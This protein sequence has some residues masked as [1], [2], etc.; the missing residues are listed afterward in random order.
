MPRFARR[1][2]WVP[3]R[4]GG[5]KTTCMYARLLLVV[6]VERAGCVWL[7]GLLDNKVCKT[8]FLHWGC[9]EVYYRTH[10]CEYVRIFIGEAVEVPAIHRTHDA[11]AKIAAWLPHLCGAATNTR[12]VVVAR[13]VCRC[14]LDGA[15]NCTVSRRDRR[16]RSG[17]RGSRAVGSDRRYN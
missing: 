16:R 5:Q 2:F 14:T 4:P 17:R 8:L 6:S 13:R 15:T 3:R 10:C 12:G 1:R 7:P 11:A 9:G